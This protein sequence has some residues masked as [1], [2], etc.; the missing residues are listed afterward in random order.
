MKKL[1]LLI[2][3]WTVFCAYHATAQEKPSFRLRT[4]DSETIA[5]D[6]GDLP[7]WEYVWRQKTN[8]AVPADDPRRVCASYFHPIFGL[9]GETLTANA[10]LDDNH[11]HHHG[12]WSSFTTVVLHT[13]DGTDA[14][15]DTWTDNTALKKD[16]IRWGG[17]GNGAENRLEITG[18][19]AVMTVENGWFLDGGEK[20]MDETLV[21]TTG[22]IQ[23]DETLGRYRTLDFSWTWRPVRDAVTLAGDRAAGKNFSS[24]AIRFARP[25][26]KPLILSDSG[27]LADDIMLGETK[28]LDYR[29]AFGE[30]K[31]EYGVAIFPSAN[32]P[33]GGEF[34]M[35]IRHYGL[36]AT[37][38]PG[39]EG[40]TLTVDT[41]VTLAYRVV[42]HEQPWT[43]EQLRAFE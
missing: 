43:V 36:I 10:T 20:I 26:E 28:W 32:N 7:V 21:V 8:E 11:A 41:P 31:K 24:L 29:A 13:S 25:T 27:E 12:L 35:A 6:D 1:F 9:D 16:F 39:L 33:P 40:V 34:G 15:Y 22:P 2:L 38:W 19:S 17:K 23:T 4:V 42:I 14:L 3:V 30:A 37:G 5:L 18:D